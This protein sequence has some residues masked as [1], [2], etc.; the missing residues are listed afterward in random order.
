[1]GDSDEGYFITMFF[2]VVILAVG[3]FV[4]FVLATEYFDTE[5]D[6][7]IDYI[8]MLEKYDNVNL[9]E[10]NI[11]LTSKEI[12]TFGKVAAMRGNARRLI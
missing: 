9:Q 7:F 1:M 4:G 10:G 5:V 11:T 2:I 6:V 12:V 3:A 8:D